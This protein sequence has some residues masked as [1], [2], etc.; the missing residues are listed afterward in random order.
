MAQ[1]AKKGKKQRKHDRNRS[2]CKVYASERRALKN[3]VRRLLK[4][5]AN[6][7]NDKIAAAALKVCKAGI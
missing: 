4:R 6:H 7:P 3:K 1:Q 2:W 5:V